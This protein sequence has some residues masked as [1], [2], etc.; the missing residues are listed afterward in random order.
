[1]ACLKKDF[2]VA[3]YNEVKILFEGC[4]G[5][6]KESEQSVLALVTLV[7]QKLLKDIKY[8]EA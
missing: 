4:A 2:A 6:R 5:G 1:M 7:V 3:V 8:P